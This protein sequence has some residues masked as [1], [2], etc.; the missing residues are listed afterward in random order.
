M[1]SFRYAKGQLLVVTPNCVTRA[2]RVRDPTCL[3][4]HVLT[5][6]DDLFR[7]TCL[8]LL[9]QQWYEFSMSENFG[10]VTIHLGPEGPSFLASMDKR[11]EDF[12]KFNYA[13]LFFFSVFLT[14]SLSS[15]SSLSFF[16]TGFLAEVVFFFCVFFNSLASLESSLI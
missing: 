4:R 8:S 9:R 7:G 11:V 16:T 10:K 1:N 2:F 5:N 3:A 13:R 12:R 15:L 14:S 6:N